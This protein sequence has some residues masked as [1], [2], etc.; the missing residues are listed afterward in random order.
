MSK[1]W[2]AIESTADGAVAHDPCSGLT[3]RLQI[4]EGVRGR[5][6]LDDRRIIELPLADVTELRRNV[7]VSICWSP[8]VTCNLHCPH[9]LDD[10]TLHEGDFALRSRVARILGETGVMGID[11]SGG[12]P[13]LIP[14]LPRLIAHLVRSGIVM[15]VTT[16]GWALQSRA[17]ELVRIVDA[18]RVSLDGSDAASHDRW[19]GPGSFVRA[20]AGMRAAINLGIPIQIQTVAMRSTI[21]ALQA[22][23]DV[24]ASEGAQGVTILQMLPIG[25]GVALAASELIPDDD[26]EDAVARLTIP[27]RL[28]I[29]L[30]RRKSASG[31]VVVR[32]DGSIWRNEPGALSIS[33]KALLSRPHD[34][35]LGLVPD[36]SA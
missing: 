2:F 31:F 9:C 12:E 16:N 6:C 18:I 1:R 10:K 13:L 33:C 34:L 17:R 26:A 25:D 20:I 30:R 5:L 7:P 11:I 22:I 21:G 35:S 3:H 4:D 29:R 32:A 28:S 19:R 23:V 27:S 8:I 14:E 24:A 15:S 36:G